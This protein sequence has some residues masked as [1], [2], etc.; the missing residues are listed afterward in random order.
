MIEAR[1][2][3]DGTTAERIYD[4]KTGSGF[5]G[6]VPAGRTATADF[7]FDVPVGAKDLDVEV[8]PG[9]DHK[10]SHWQLTL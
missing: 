7:A 6:S 5:S 9:F 1:A 4:S 8:R 10:A 3:K 2:G